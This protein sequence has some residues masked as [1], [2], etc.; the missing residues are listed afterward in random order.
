MKFEFLK[1][2]RF[3]KLTIVAVL[4]VLQQNNVIDGVLY[5]AIARVIEIVFSGSVVLRTI[6]KFNE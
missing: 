3:W 1:S 6:D 4:V 5:E 2:V